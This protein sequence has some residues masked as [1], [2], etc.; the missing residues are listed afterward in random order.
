MKNRKPR[1]IA[2][3]EVEVQAWKYIFG[4]D[5]GLFASLL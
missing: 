5:F 4:V 3:M 2:R 1:K